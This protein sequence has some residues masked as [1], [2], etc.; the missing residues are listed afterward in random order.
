MNLD[1]RDIKTKLLET[2]GNEYIFI[3]IN[4]YICIYMYIYVCSYMCKCMGKCL[5][6]C[7]LKTKS[8]VV[9]TS[10]PKVTIRVSYVIYLLPEVI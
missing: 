7:I 1:Q 10:V 2:P 6:E 8:C 5:N 4:I 9:C 3:F